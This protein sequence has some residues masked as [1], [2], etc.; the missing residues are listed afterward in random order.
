[1][2]YKFQ[3]PKTLPVVI[4]ADL[5]KP[6]LLTI[7]TS[8]PVLRVSGHAELQLIVSALLRHGEMPLLIQTLSLAAVFYQDI[9]AAPK[10]YLEE[11]EWAAN[12]KMTA[13]AGCTLFNAASACIF[14]TEIAYCV[15]YNQL[16]RKLRKIVKNKYRYQK[17]FEWVPPALRARS[18][19]R[20]FKAY[21]KTRAELSFADRLAAALAEQTLAPEDAPL[22]LLARQSQ[23][24]AVSALSQTTVAP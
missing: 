5:E 8:A 9:I 18:A 16:N 23:T 21:V 22:T 2:L 11:L 7:E 4:L 12:V 14:A 19:V 20:L 6:T 3:K 10:L 24:T 13:A 17:R 1:M 15:R